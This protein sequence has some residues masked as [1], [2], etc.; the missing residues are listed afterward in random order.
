ME[1][2]LAVIPKYERDLKSGKTGAADHSVLVTALKVD[3]MG[4]SLAS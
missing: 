4:E 3:F 2:L 1:T